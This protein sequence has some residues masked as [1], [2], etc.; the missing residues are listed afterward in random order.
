M[1]QKWDE[2]PMHGRHPTRVNTPDVVIE[3]IHKWLKSP[4]LKGET[5]GLLIAAQ[6]QT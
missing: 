4:G 3:M 2:K 1:R 5:E 6:D